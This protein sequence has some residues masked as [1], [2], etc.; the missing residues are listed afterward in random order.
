M[1][2]KAKRFSMGVAAMLLTVALLAL[3]AGAAWAADGSVAGPSVVDQIL[4]TVEGWVDSAWSWILG[5]NGE[6]ETQNMGFE[7]EPNG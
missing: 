4:E 1:D 2:L 3:P 6:P 7:I 5:D